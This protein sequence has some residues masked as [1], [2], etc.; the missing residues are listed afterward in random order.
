M[1]RVALVLIDSGLM[2]VG[3]R[4]DVS[5][6]SPGLALIDGD[7]IA[8]GTEAVRHAR[9]DPRRIH[10]RFWQELGN[11]PLGRPFP[12][13]LRTSDLAHA[14]LTELWQSLGRQVDEAILV[15]PGT[16]TGEQLA[17][18]L[19][20]AAAAGIP[21]RGL[22]DAAVAAAA[23]R[24]TRPR[25]LHLDLHLHRAVLTELVHGTQV[26]R[27]RVWEDDRTGMLRMHDVWARTVAGL[28][29]RHTRFDPLHRAASE[30]LLYL[31]LPGLVEA[32]GDGDAARCTID[33]GGREHAIEV[34]R[35]SLVEASRDTVRALSGW[36][37]EHADPASTTLL[38]SRTMASIPGLVSRL[39]DEAGFDVSVVHP[40]AAGSSALRHAGSIRSDEKA[41]PFVTRLPGY[42]ARPPG[43]VT[44]A[45]HPPGADGLPAPPTHLV[46]DGA[47]RRI[48][49]APIAIGAGAGS[50][51]AVTVRR[52]GP[53]VVVE[54]PPGVRVT[55][56]GQ[57]VAAAAALFVGD[58]LVV[59]GAVDEVLL[60]TTDPP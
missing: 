28:F 13:H 4:G 41:L 47:A 21:A 58:R 55:V 19:G 45:V 23:D 34:D 53:R 29:V 9:S 59:D 27:G 24:A 48:T 35:R 52:V 6:P 5:E 1:E 18:L 57:E 30:Q 31:R 36:A 38:V 32:L 8:V 15:V 56:N 50:G 39:A 2:T 20:T 22:V 40:A 42:D 54:A 37:L 11:E 26:V 60:I 51:D 25:C 3:A 43:A 14:H 17:L 16:A 7:R 46:I 10:S 33:S 44:V 49:E 12:A